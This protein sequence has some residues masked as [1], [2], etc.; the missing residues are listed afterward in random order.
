[1][2]ANGSRAPAYDTP[3][4]IKPRWYRFPL[5]TRRQSAYIVA[6]SATADYGDKRHPE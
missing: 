3:V 5:Q 2:D 1:L 6:L 4:P